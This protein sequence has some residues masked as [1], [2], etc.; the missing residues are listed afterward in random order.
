VNS[1]PA[2]RP[3]GRPLVHDL[4]VRN[5]DESEPAHGIRRRPAEAGVCAGT[6][7]SQQRQAPPETTEGAPEKTVAA[8]RCFF[9][10]TLI[11]RISSLEI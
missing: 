9:V 8:G 11:V 2:A 3:G 7:E 1:K 4:A 10:I 5:I 6:M